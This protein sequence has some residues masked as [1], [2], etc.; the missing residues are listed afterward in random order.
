MPQ[1]VTHRYLNYFFFHVVFQSI[2]LELIFN[3]ISFSFYLLMRREVLKANKTRARY[4]KYFGCENQN[5][6][7]TE[8]Q[9]TRGGVVLDH[10]N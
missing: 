4:Y 9:I 1:S 6:N 5:G 3:C 2:I 10:W 7:L 8:G